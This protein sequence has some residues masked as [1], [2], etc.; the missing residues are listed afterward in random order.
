MKS[1]PEFDDC[2]KK[3]KIVPFPLAKKLV[4]KE[5]KAAEQD[6]ETALRSIKQKDYKWATIQ[7][8]YAMFHAARTLL[9]HKG[10]REKSHYCLMLAM[11]TFYVSEGKLEMRLAESLQTA[12]ALRESADYDNIFDKNSAISLVDQAAEFVKVAQTV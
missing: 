5:L 2:L 4:A 12:R 7:A 1:H 10:Y 9:F 11:K 6:L 8:Y 3:G